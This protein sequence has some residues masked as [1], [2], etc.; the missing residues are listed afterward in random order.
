MLVPKVFLN[1]TCA[2][3]GY[4]GPVQGLGEGVEHGVG[5]VLLQGVPQPREDEHPHADR[6]RQQQQLPDIDDDDGKDDYDVPGL[7]V[8]VS[9]CCPQCLEARD[10]AGK[11]ENSENSENSEDLRCLGDI[12]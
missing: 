10:V 8:A 3:H 5:L 6:H 9:Q 11:F 1:L 4:D 2:C 12:F 7:P